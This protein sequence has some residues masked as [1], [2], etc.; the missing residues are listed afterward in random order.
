[1]PTQETEGFQ[2]S[3]EFSPVWLAQFDHLH[4]AKT[5]GDV[6]RDILQNIVL[7]TCFATLSRYRQIVACGL[8]VLEGESVGLYD[9]VTDPNRRR[10]GFS[11]AL[12]LNMLHWA[13]QNGATQAYL[14]V[15]ANNSPALG[16]YAKLGFTEVYRYWYRVLE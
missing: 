3:P 15:E 2:F 8:G 5:Q 12:I 1:M 9:I 13:K 11:Y 7:P 10:K 4:G 16:L 14:S 6:H